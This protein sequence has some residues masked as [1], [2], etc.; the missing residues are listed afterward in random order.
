MLSD[1][2]AR[3]MNESVMLRRGAATLL[4]GGVVDPT[5]HLLRP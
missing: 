5:Y 1:N 2:F 3:L 4:V